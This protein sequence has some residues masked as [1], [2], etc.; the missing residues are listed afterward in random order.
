[1]TDERER[2]R[3]SSLSYLNLLKIVA[4]ICIVLFHYYT[5]T[6]SQLGYDNPIEEKTFFG[7]IA[8][9][10]YV[11][12]ELFFM[13]SG[14]LFV[15]YTIPKIVSG[16][17]F[18][19]FIIKKVVRLWPLML[20]TTISFYLLTLLFFF[21]NKAYWGPASL[22]LVYLA[23]DSFFLHYLFSNAL[24]FNAPVWYIIVL[25]LVY[26][27]AYIATLIYKKYKS[28]L[29]Y[30]LPIFIALA[31]SYSKLQLELAICARGLLSFFIG[32]YLGFLFEFIRKKNFKNTSPGM[33]ILRV[34]LVLELALALSIVYSP[35][36]KEFI[37]SYQ[38]YFMIYVFPPL[39]LLLYNVKWISKITDN[40]YINYLGGMSYS[41]Y[42]WDFPILLFVHIIAFNTSDSSYVLQWWNVLIVVLIHLLVGA[43]SYYLVELKLGKYLMGLF[44]KYFN[45]PT[46]LIEN[47]N[48]VSP[49]ETTEEKDD[50]D[51]D[52]NKIDENNEKN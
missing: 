17:K 11:F 15:I 28:K 34:L 46:A 50:K 48:D 1:M 16:E 40:K 5:S 43:L 49:T 2:E 36:E 7:F 44:N 26:V 45:K 27:F 4:A 6:P 31:V 9:N 3:E 52:N 37:S 13:I 14:L 12:V 39:L 21:V 23:Y 19:H 32:V 38:E 51:D 33:I 42:L 20:I 10:S 41:I 8:Y 29:I 24:L 22:N 47:S 35:Y 30:L 25:M 18:N